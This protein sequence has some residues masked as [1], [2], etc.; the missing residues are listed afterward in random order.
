MTSIKPILLFVK[1]LNC[2]EAII[3]L[4]QLRIVE[5]PCQLLH[6]A[7]SDLLTVFRFPTSVRIRKM[8]ELFENITNYILVLV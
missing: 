2:N 4:S 6:S 1:F 5:Y 8:N 3:V 7:H